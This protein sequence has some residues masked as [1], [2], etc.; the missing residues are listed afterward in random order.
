MNYEVVNNTKEAGC[1]DIGFPVLSAIASQ[2][3]TNELT[4]AIQG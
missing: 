1:T 3:V 2:I 4:T